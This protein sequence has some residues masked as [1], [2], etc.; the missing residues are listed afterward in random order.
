MTGKT[1]LL[2]GATGLVGRELLAALLADPAVAA[3]HAL[4]RR[5]LDVQHPK[6]TS[7][8]VD[9]AALPSL[10]RIDEAYVALGTTIKVAGS[11]AAFRAVDLDA[12]TAV[13][14]AAQSA[15]ATKL[16]IVSA[17]GADPSSRVFYNRVK[18]EMEQKVRALGIDT[19]VFARPSLLEGD[20][21]SLQQPRRPA[22]RWLQA[23]MRALRPVTPANLRAIAARDVAVSLI[24][25]LRT[26]APGA[27]V[28]LSGAL[29]RR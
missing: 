18:G 16:G 14:R 4:G 26:R 5:A 7:H 27:H 6:L 23:A 13:A 25:A 8:V 15:G 3:V 1:V 12:V 22:E 11:Q 9:F 17:M 24:E 21:A 19:T 28:L 29:Q 20:R 10:P 2:A